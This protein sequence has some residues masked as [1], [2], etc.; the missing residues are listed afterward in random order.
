MGHD[1]NFVKTDGL[2]VQAPWRGVDTADWGTPAFRTAVDRYYGFKPEERGC[3]SCAYGWSAKIADA[4]TATGVLVEME[5]P[6]PAPAQW[7]VDKSADEAVLT[8][9]A[10]T[11]LSQGAGQPFRVPSFKFSSSDGWIFSPAECLWMAYAL[12]PHPD[13]DMRAFGRFCEFAARHGGF[14]AD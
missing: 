8:P 11:Y 6:S 13:A 14:T 1:F 3:Y 7:Y 10:R 12:R 2:P 9:E 4:L 5:P